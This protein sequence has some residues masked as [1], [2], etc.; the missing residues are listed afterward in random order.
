MSKIHHFLFESINRV[1]IKITIAVMKLSRGRAFY[2]RISKGQC[3]KCGVRFFLN[4]DRTQDSKRN[5]TPSTYPTIM[6]TH[7][8]QWNEKRKHL[9]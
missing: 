2:S 4:I 6:Y 7:F 1:G 8:S 5:I 9:A 3:V